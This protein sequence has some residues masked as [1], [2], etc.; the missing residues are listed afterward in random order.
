MTIVHIRSVRT[1]IDMCSIAGT[2]HIPNR[3]SLSTVYLSNSTTVGA[4]SSVNHYAL[5]LQIVNVVLNILY[6]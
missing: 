1:S 3:V 4:H 5:L 2:I 6:Q